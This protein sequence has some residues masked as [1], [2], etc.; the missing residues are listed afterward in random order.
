MYNRSLDVF[1]AVAE[2]ASFTKAAQQLYISHTAVIKQMNQLET[3]LGVKLFYRSHKGITL[4]I[5]GQQLYLE[6]L[7]IIKHSNQAIQ[8]VQE[9]HFASPQTLRVGSSLLYP[10][11]HFMDIWDKINE[12]CPQFKLN[13]VSFTDEE[14]RLVHLHHDFDFLISPYNDDDVEEGLLFF[15]IG[16]YRFCLTMP[17]NHAL[18]NKKE[19]CFKDLKHQTLMIMKSGTSPINDQIRKDIIEHYPDIIIE[20]IPPHYSLSTF[21]QCVEEN[22]IL[23][24][25]DCWQQVHPSLTSIKLQEEYFMPY[26]IILLKEAKEKLDTFMIALQNILHEN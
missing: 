15:P 7:E 14:K 10:C 13:I 6:T 26:G 17:K 22:T 5:A 18:S 25:L 1:K 12:Q 8:R 16:Y 3:H 20:D 24:S 2:N 9:A 19:L 11:H 4:T 21:N 23:L